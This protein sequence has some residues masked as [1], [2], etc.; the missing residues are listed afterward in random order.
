MPWAI[1]KK[2]ADW[3][4]PN[5]VYAFTAEASAEP[6]ERPRDFIDHCV[7]IG[8]AEEV[9]APNGKGENRVKAGSR[10]S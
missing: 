2:R 3:S 1:F 6:Q 7:A 5:S 4:R 9:P 8:A 10:P